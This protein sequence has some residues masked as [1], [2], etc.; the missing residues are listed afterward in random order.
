[1][2]IY[3]QKGEE[4]ALNPWKE[5]N[6]EEHPGFWEESFGQENRRITLYPFAVERTQL[7]CQ[8]KGMNNTYDLNWLDEIP[9]PIWGLDETSSSHPDRAIWI[10][11][12]QYVG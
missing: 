1:V 11:I 10:P 2:S 6:L 4:G 8:P 7:L 9:P 5:K 12:A 3:R